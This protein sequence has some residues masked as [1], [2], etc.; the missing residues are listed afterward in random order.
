MIEAIFEIIFGFIGELLFELVV[1]VLVEFGFHRT[2]EK[3]SSQTRSRVFVGSAYLLFGAIL[4]AVSIYFFPKI[5]FGSSVLPILYFI[6]SPIIA[7]LSLTSVSYFINKDTRPVR[8]FELDKFLF[9]VLFAV[10]Y[11]VV[12]VVFG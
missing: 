1:E 10:A 8:W 12:R 5:E 6:V 4:G 7:G 2:A 3:F 9:G 11:S